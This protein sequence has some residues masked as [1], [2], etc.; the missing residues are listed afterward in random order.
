MMPDS[1][2]KC[3]VQETA[4]YPAINEIILMSIAALMIL[5]GIEI[6]ANFPT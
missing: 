5:I 6:S 4:V 1:G 3:E 2:Q